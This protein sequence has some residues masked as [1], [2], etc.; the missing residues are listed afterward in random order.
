MAG[1]EAQPVPCRASDHTAQ[2]PIS[3]RSSR[4][5]ATPRALSHKE[6][7]KLLLRQVARRLRR[8]LL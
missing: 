7:G 4:S 6:D 3:L 1:S 8:L 2:G 5:P